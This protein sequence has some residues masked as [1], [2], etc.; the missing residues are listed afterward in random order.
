[1]AALVEQ[2]KLS[3]AD[4]ADLKRI[5]RILCIP[6]DVAIKVRGLPAAAAPQKAPEGDAVP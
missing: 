3:E 2:G 1:M 4:R 6:S 5:R